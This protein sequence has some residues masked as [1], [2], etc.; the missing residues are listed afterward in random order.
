MRAHLLVRQNEQKEQN[1][2]N[3]IVYRLHARENGLSARTYVSTVDVF[4]FFDELSV[5]DNNCNV[6]NIRQQLIRLIH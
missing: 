5:I 6:N 2:V 3:V 1:K 4:V